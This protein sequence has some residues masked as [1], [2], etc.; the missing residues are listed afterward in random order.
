MLIDS[1][2]KAESMN[3]G[4]PTGLCTTTTCPH[5][6]RVIE[7]HVLYSPYS[8]RNRMYYRHLDC[9]QQLAFRRLLK[10]CTQQN[11]QLEDVDGHDPIVAAALTARLL[12]LGFHQDAQGVWKPPL[13]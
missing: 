4:Y 8:E 3:I 5:N 12:S 2:D 11:M 6:R 9:C 13:R 1:A 7:G 10:Q